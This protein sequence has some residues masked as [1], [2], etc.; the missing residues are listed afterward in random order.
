MKQMADGPLVTDSTAL[1]HITL[2][3]QQPLEMNTFL[4]QTRCIRF[5]NIFLENGYLTFVHF[6]LT[7]VLTKVCNQKYFMHIE[8]STLVHVTYM[9]IYLSF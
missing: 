1:I 8:I 5:K 6:F 4:K 9:N 2:S 7:K 3:T